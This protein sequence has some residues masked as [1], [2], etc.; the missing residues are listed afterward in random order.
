MGHTHNTKFM[1]YFIAILGLFTNLAFGELQF[2]KGEDQI[3]MESR[4]SERE[5][6]YQSIESFENY[7]YFEEDNSVY[8][9]PCYLTES[10]IDP[11]FVERE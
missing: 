7:Q 5:Y 11:S 3:M 9:Y 4:N 2:Y 10:L 6:F 8:G 1:L